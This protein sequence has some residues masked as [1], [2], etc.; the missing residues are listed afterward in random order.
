MLSHIVVKLLEVLFDYRAVADV[1]MSY[2]LVAILVYGNDGIQKLLD[3]PPCGGY[4]GD[5]GHTNHLSQGLVVELG[6][7]TLQLV[8]HIESYDHLG[9]Y[10]DKLC[11]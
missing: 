6:T 2:A 8:I 5:Y 9:A 4:N 3:A 1:D 11:G 10:I 7:A